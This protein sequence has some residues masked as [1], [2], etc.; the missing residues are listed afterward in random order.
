MVAAP[1][2]LGLS[3]A[4]FLPLTAVFG[5]LNQSSATAHFVQMS[6]GIHTP[7][8]QP[9]LWVQTLRL[10]LPLLREPLRS[11]RCQHLSLLCQ[12]QA[13]THLHSPVVDLDT[14]EFLGS[15]RS[16]VGATEQDLGHTTAASL[17][18]VG[19]KHLFDMT[20]GLAKVVLN[21]SNVSRVCRAT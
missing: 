21:Q 7:R 10:G 19:K 3:F 18:P 5:F 20:D 2:V 15:F 16:G 13:R 14:I 11:N 12:E 9:V 6:K 1:L 17:G 4:S 8:D